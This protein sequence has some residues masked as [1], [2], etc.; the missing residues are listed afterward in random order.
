ML[1]L[2]NKS[3]VAMY[4]GTT[5][6]NKILYNNL[7]LLDNT[8]D[9]PADNP[10]GQSEPQ[11]DDIEISS[12]NK[13]EAQSVTYITGDRAYYYVKKEVDVGDLVYAPSTSTSKYGVAGYV[14]EVETADGS[15]LYFKP[16]SSYEYNYN[17]VYTDTSNAIMLTKQS[18]G[19]IL[20]TPEQLYSGS[21]AWISEDGQRVVY[22]SSIPTGNTSKTAQKAY[23]NE[24][25]TV[26]YLLNDS[27][28]ISPSTIYARLYLV[29]YEEY[30]LDN[31]AKFANSITMY[32]YKP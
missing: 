21:Y 32:P 31:S 2:N 11:T 22:T 19:T 16:N 18:G 1:I 8:A 12:M 13:F 27:T 25:L 30:L 23:S 14:T 4:Y 15:T 26:N 28:V 29:G 24:A 20:E 3:I 9:E 5:K 17:Q 10:G 6:I 7:T